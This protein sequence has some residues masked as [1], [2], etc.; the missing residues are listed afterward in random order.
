MSYLLDA[1]SYI[2]AKNFHYRMKFCPGFWDWLDSSAQHGKLCSISMVYKELADFGDELSDWVKK[3]QDH[4]EGIDDSDTQSV[5]GTIAQ[6]VMD[7]KLPPDTEKIRFLD[8]ADPWLIAKALTTGKTVVTHE[9]I[10][11]DNSRKIKIP[12]ICKDFGVNYINSFDLLDTL[13]ARF[14]MEHA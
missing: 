11:P 14:V 10:A 12:N 13:Q 9:V 1:N 3:R 6:H 8:G 5:F 7:L 4:F 2:Q